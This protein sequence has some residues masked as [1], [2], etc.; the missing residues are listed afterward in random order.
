MT[1]NTETVTSHSPLSTDGKQVFP[2]I[3]LKDN[4][5][6]LDIGEKSLPCEG[7]EALE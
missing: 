2:S 5:V 6:N 3:K 7:G 1:E 4:R